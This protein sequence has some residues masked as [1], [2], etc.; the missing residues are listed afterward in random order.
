LCWDSIISEGKLEYPEK[1]VD[2]S[3]VMDSCIKYTSTWAGTDIIGRENPTNIQSW[4][5]QPALSCI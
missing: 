5:P 3:Q 1:T 2:L 4:L